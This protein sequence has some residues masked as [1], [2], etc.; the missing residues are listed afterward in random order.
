VEQL[1]E[2]IQQLQ[3]CIVDLELCAV[4]KTLQD[5]RYLTE[6]IVHNI[7]DRLKAL[8]LDYKKLSNRS[9]QMYEKLVENPKLQ[10]LES[11]LQEAK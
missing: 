11:Q 4:P 5:V 3:Q 9:A 2:V 8:S 6:A 7:V 10:A 1:E